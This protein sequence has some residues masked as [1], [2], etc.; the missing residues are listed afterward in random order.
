MRSNTRRQFLIGCTTAVAASGVLSGANE[1]GASVDGKKETGGLQ[2]EPPEA[3]TGWSTMR[4]DCGR[5]AAVGTVDGFDEGYEFD[6]LETDWRTDAEALPVVV[7]GTAYLSDEGT[8]QALNAADGTL[9]WRSED[10]ATDGQPTAAYGNVYVSGDDTVAALD[11]ATGDVRWQTAVA[12]AD[13][14]AIESPT[15]AFGI[16]YAFAG[17]SL[18]AVDCETGTVEW[19]RESISVSDGDPW[20]TQTAASRALES[21]VV[22][23]DDCIFSIAEE[24]TIACLNP[25]TGECE[26]AIETDYYYLYDLVATENKVFVRTESEV[27]AAYDSSTGERDEI[28]HGGIRR[29]AVREDVL[30]FAT[31][32]KLIAVDL[33]TGDERWSIGKYS[34]AIGDPVIAHDTVLVSVGLQGGQYENSL[35][36]FDIESGVEQWSYSRSESANVGERCAVADRTIYIDDDGLTAIRASPDDREDG[37]EGNERTRN[38]GSEAESEVT[39]RKDD[40]GFEYRQRRNQRSRPYRRSERV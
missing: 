19:V 11:A 38:C 37:T 9:E 40:T 35:V 3:A 31:R 22:A 34:H 2:S 8:V 32:Y 23:A 18:T 13:G 16:V 28:W 25:L 24:G 29:V 15:V 1:A 20:T 36:A 39:G 7:D 27:V 26:L 12:S 6:A 10:V 4:G 14:A 21:C 30:L 17:G 33:E 5:T